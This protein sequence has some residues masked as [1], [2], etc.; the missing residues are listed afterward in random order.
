MQ[1]HN[2]KTLNIPNTITPDTDITGL[3]NDIK[4]NFEQ[5]KMADLYRGPKGDSL[6]PLS[7]DFNEIFVY[8]GNNNTT[9][10]FKLKDLNTVTNPRP[11]NKYETLRDL[12]LEIVKAIKED[13]GNIGSDMSNLDGYELFWLE[14][15]IKA[16]DIGNYREAF[17]LFKKHSDNFLP[18]SIILMVD[19]TDYSKIYYTNHYTFVDPRFRAG[20]IKDFNNKVKTNQKDISCAV[21]GNSINKK[22]NGNEVVELVFS[23]YNA[24]PQLTYNKT[25]KNFTWKMNGQITSIPAAGQKGDKGEHGSI[26]VVTRIEKTDNNSNVYK[27][28]SVNGKSLYKDENIGKFEQKVDDYDK[29]VK[30]YSGLPCIIRPGS[31]YKPAYQKGSLVW[32]GNIQY[33]ETDKLLEVPCDSG[34]QMN[35]GADVNNLLATMM[36]LSVYK[37]WGDNDGSVPARGLVLPI[38][39]KDGSA[40]YLYTDV[41][42]PVL[43][44]S[45]KNVLHIDTIN[46]INKTQRADEHKPAVPDSP[47]SYDPSDN[48]YE[49][50]KNGN[51]DYNIY[52]SVK[53]HPELVLNKT[54]IVGDDIKGFEYEIL[55]LPYLKA[56]Y[57]NDITGAR[58]TVIINDS[59]RSKQVLGEQFGNVV[60]NK[61]NNKYE[62]KGTWKNG[63]LSTNKTYVGTSRA[64]NGFYYGSELEVP[65]KGVL[66][67]DGKITDSNIPVIYD[68]GEYY[69]DSRYIEF[70][71][72]L[73]YKEPGTNKWKFVEESER[74]LIPGNIRPEDI[75]LVLIGE[76]LNS[77]RKFKKGTKVFRRLANE[78][79]GEVT[80]EDVGHNSGYVD[81][82]VTPEM[83][84]LNITF[85]IDQAFVGLP[86]NRYID[87]FRARKVGFGLRLDQGKDWSSNEGRS[88]QHWGMIGGVYY[89]TGLY[90]SNYSGYKSGD[91][92]LS[93][94]YDETYILESGDKYT[95]DDIVAPKIHSSIA[96]GDWPAPHSYKSIPWVYPKNYGP[97]LDGPFGMRGEYDSPWTDGGIHQYSSPNLN[98][99]VMNTSNGYAGAKDG[100]TLFEQLYNHIDLK[101]VN[102]IL[103]EEGIPL[104]QN[105]EVNF[106][107]SSIEATWSGNLGFLGHP[108]GLDRNW[109]PWDGYMGNELYENVQ[110]HQM[111][112]NFSLSHYGLRIT[113]YMGTGCITSKPGETRT[114]SFIYPNPQFGNQKDP[115]KQYFI[116]KTDYLYNYNS[117]D[118]K[119]GKID[120]V[121]GDSLVED[122]GYEQYKNFV[123]DSDYESHKEY[124]SG[125]F[126]FRIQ[127]DG[128][129]IY[130]GNTNSNTYKYF[131]SKTQLDLTSINKIFELE[132]S[133]IKTGDQNIQTDATY[134][135]K[136]SGI[137]IDTTRYVQ[138]SLL[139]TYTSQGGQGNIQEN[140]K[141]TLSNITFEGNNKY[142][143]NILTSSFIMFELDNATK[144]PNKWYVSGI[145]DNP[146]EYLTK[147]KEAFVE[148]FNEIIKRQGNN[149]TPVIKIKFPEGEFFL[150]SYDNI[151]ESFTGNFYYEAPLYYLDNNDK[152]KW[153]DEY[154]K[155]KATVTFN[156]TLGM[157]LT[158][159]S[160]F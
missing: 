107:L 52:P 13:P 129:V 68:Q 43:D 130:N 136:Y 133:N 18:G 152:G 62:S 51:S 79:A 14:K 17:N 126:G 102:R 108:V 118:P 31:T 121:T 41:D 45:L 29:I 30:L 143:I 98:K 10:N 64:E 89:W 22:K 37:N 156:K 5:L 77:E 83:V 82:I 80:M 19:S 3:L 105:T 114:I 81:Y 141:F 132:S 97:V 149:N 124:G 139:H 95:F 9:H 104:P 56:G 159:W 128:K 53:V 11:F 72:K 117:G 110:G 134:K 127:K 93:L 8:S 42:E 34:N 150:N 157:V 57:N 86:W 153:G 74:N 4:Y 148:L 146:G 94:Q 60:Y 2:L 116:Y 32:F 65:N 113:D 131:I 103:N 54:H 87:N 27:V 44:N 85:R 109:S 26:V 92:I 6:V 15:W 40:F 115:S 33:N 106:L 101:G 28:A 21:V 125:N 112:V 70:K 144:L 75:Q 120:L 78:I 7:I 46:D 90:S 154:L 138:L 147:T 39:E 84:I 16:N 48:F 100:K 63:V 35:I 135:Y 122:N 73:K 137:L 12:Y 59:I 96:L 99:R 160:T 91:N 61:Q 119:P 151:Q 88:F 47:N 145:G 49:L 140:D 76:N 69:G 111:G 67:G 1:T 20:D 71:R 142:S 24:F 55:N 123:T 66:F 36:D 158:N 155:L 58:N 25:L 23:V 50:D 38:N